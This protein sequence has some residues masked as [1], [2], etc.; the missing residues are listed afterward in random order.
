M[1]ILIPCPHCGPRPVEEFVYGEVPVVPEEITD[2]EERD[3]DFGFMRNNPE[4]VQREAWFHAYGCRR[5]V[6]IERD[7]V[8]DEV[9][10][11]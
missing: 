11:R 9:I 8:N 10:G 6:Y 2:P 4:G 3:F 1:S 5:W 7:T